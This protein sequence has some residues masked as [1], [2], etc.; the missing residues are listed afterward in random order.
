MEESWRGLCPTFER[1]ARLYS[2]GETIIGDIAAHRLVA[3]SPDIRRFCE[4]EV[5]QL[6]RLSARLY[7]HAARLGAIRH[8]WVRNGLQMVEDEMMMRLENLR[9]F[10]ALLEAAESV[11]ASA[12]CVVEGKTLGL[13]HRA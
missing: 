7:E 12:S 13:G 6:L 9:S 1:I 10:R 11:P 2:D 3:A 5:R 4:R 8:D